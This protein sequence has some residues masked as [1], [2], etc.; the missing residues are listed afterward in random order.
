MYETILALV[1]LAALVLYALFAGA[2]F[3]GGMWDLR[4][5][6]P[7]RR[8]QQEAI[9]DAIGPV[10]EANHVWLIL[11]IVILFAAF[12]PAFGLVMTALFFPMIVVLIGIVLRGAT[13]IFRKYDVQRDAVHRRWS[14]VFGI[15]SFLTPFFLGLCL[16]ALATGGIR[17]VDGVLVSGFYAGWTSPFAIGCGLFAQGLFAYLAAVYMTV[18]TATSPEVQAD[19]RV[20]ALVS[21]ATLAPAAWL[22]FLLADDG[23]PFLFEGLTRWW[24]PLLAGVVSVLGIGTVAA[25]WVRRFAWAR[26]G[27]MVQVA[28][29]LVGWGVAQYPY[30]IVPD[31]TFSGV[32]TSTATLR[33]LTW[34]LAAGTVLLLPAFVY[35][36]RIFKTTTT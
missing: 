14:V 34:T 16:G 24:S 17:V 33:L 18:E 1:M 20:R 21:A 35:L 31:I 2:D 12:P 9:A 6:G 36:F 27:A 13:F 28:L 4:A 25:L 26:I 10:W 30:I 15:A 19:F 5:S 7:N 32:A 22:V 11:V 29:I 8:K 23:A 3:G